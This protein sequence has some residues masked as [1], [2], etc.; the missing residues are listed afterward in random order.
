MVELK[1]LQCRGKVLTFSIFTG[2][3]ITMETKIPPKEQAIRIIN[4][5]ILKYSEEI[6]HSASKMLDQKDD[7]ELPKDVPLHTVLK[8]VV[9]R[10]YECL[11]EL[12]SESRDKNTRYRDYFLSTIE[13]IEQLESI[14][15]GKDFPKAAKLHDAC[16]LSKYIEK[17][18]KAVKQNSKF[19]QTTLSGDII[20]D[21]Q[22]CLADI[23]A[24][25]HNFDGKPIF[26]IP[27]T[28]IFDKSGKVNADFTGIA[29]ILS[30]NGKLTQEMLE[31]LTLTKLE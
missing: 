17:H 22:I 6:E 10:L 24:M 16:R 31:E 26:S 19:K 12:S 2:Y 20:P 9:M 29:S 3:K 18:S 8:S 25:E 13:V 5:H 1:I 4:A 21:H 7:F 14:I 27:F 30:K 28:S 23:L 11:D 15:D